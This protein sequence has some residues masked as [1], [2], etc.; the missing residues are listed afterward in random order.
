M[1]THDPN[2]RYVHIGEDATRD[3]RSRVKTLGTALLLLSLA[4]AALLVV[5]AGGL[6]ASSGM[7][8]VFPLILGGISV[9][10]AF[11]TTLTLT[12]VGRTARRDGW[13]NTVEVWQ[14][15]RMRIVFTSAIFVLTALAELLL[16]AV[17][18]TADSDTPLP[19]ITYF[20]LL[21][22]PFVLSFVATKRGNRVVRLQG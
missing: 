12:M 19:A 4:A 17:V 15:R 18:V 14:L 3:I 7:T 11:L 20:V 9:F 6:I 13:F 5:L 8:A 16:A 22:A 10:F 2:Q 21:A 1:T